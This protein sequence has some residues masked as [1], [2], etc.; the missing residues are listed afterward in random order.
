MTV[1]EGDEIN[2][3]CSAV[4]IPEPNVVLS[5]TGASRNMQNLDR[6]A[7]VVIRRAEKS[8]AGV[9]ECTATSVAGTDTR[10]IQVYVQEK[11]GDVGE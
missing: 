3:S 6:K 4:G 9:Y 11:R 2:I 10:Y 7:S 8:D 1:T 5:K